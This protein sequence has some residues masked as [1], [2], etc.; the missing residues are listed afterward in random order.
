LVVESY[1]IPARVSDQ[2][3]GIG[4]TAGLGK[5][6]YQGRI[7]WDYVKQQLKIIGIKM[8]NSFKQIVD[9]AGREDRVY[10]MEHEVKAILEGQDISTTRSL[11]AR[12]GTRL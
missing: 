6:G 1:P 12:S 10:L 4:I 11:V 2:A 3:N 5:K 9:Q 8:T 7:I